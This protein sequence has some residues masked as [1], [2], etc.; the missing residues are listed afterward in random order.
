MS[1]FHT[2]SHVQILKNFQSSKVGLSL[3]VVSERQIYSKDLQIKDDKSGSLLLKFL[4]Q[5]SD[6]MV[7]ILLFASLT[8]IVVGIIQ[9]SSAEIVDGVIIFSIVF[10]NALF[11]FIQE[12]KSEKAISSLK[13]MAEPEC[14]VIRQGEAFKIPSCSLVCG[15]IVVLESGSQ[16]PADCR[17]IE[18]FSLVV[19]ESSL[20]G[21]SLPVKKNYAEI[22]NEK[23]A[24]GDRSN[25]VF[26]GTTVTGGRGVCIVCAIG[27]ETE[28]GKIAL[29]IKETKKELTPLQ[30][31]I[32]SV[33][34]VLTYLI[35]LIAFVTFVLEIVA[36]GNPM[37]AFLTAIAISV[38]AI[39][40][41]LP[42]VI[43]IIMSIGIFRLAKQKAIVKRMH[44]VETLGCCDVICSDKTGTITQNKMTVVET[45]CDGS[46]DKTPNEE[47]FKIISLCNDTMKG[48]KGFAGDPTEIAISNFAKKHGYDK[49]LMEK[50]FER[51]NEKSFDS[52]RRMMSVVNKC[53][54][55]TMFTK[56]A[57]WEVLNSCDRIWTDGKERLLTDFDRKNILNANE[58]MTQKA[59]RVLSLAF[60][61]AE[62]DK[63]EE[64]GLVFVGLVGMIDPPRKQT[65]HAVERCKKAGIRTIMITGDHKSTAFAIAKQVKIAQSEKEVFTGSEI[66][67]MGDEQL[68]KALKKASVFARVS[69]E[70]KSRLVKILKENGHIVGMTGD[71]VNDAPSIKSA[72]IGIGMGQ[73]GVD[74]TKEVADIIIT[75]DNFSTIVVAVE[76]GRKIF[77]NIQKTVKFLF[78]ANMA[79]IL[80]LFLMTIIFPKLTFLLP[81]QILFVNLITDSLPA[82]ALGVEKAENNIMEES[83]RSKKSN[84]FSNGVW[85]EIVVMGIVQTIL[86]M[87]SYVIGL[88]LVSE[89]TAVTM[90]FYTLNLLQLFYLF[91]VRTDKMVFKTNPFKNK[92]FTLSMI[93]GFGMLLIIALTPLSKVL[94][95]V[96]LSWNMWLIVFAIS[97]LVIFFNEIYKVINNKFKK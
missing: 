76:E 34:K 47:F 14:T 63:I 92:L 90:A 32:K 67:E 96:E 8:S 2:Y 53:D 57:I 5:F 72:S 81:I 79:E 80:S 86:I 21:E 10:V 52:E 77:K 18:S 56:G 70:N 58:K 27:I 38:A 82:I 50:K 30:K 97:V 48:E 1:K 3:S 16:V 15:D 74:V 33:G 88:Y 26:K 83:P 43:T 36:R 40:E 44:S 7:L 39:P 89:Q 37:Q 71:G 93:F 4:M 66:D 68:S 94:G 75:D 35:L 31:N 62:G 55:L 25:M 19:D 22:L 84:L 46:F 85:R 45:F 12:Y 95:L 91:S 20:T 65:L 42:A 78:S 17:L 51:V 87:S 60:K 28:I 73:S 59:L 29:V 23:T 24:L 64:K 54:N 69:P 6:L 9:K 13:K 49:I 41:S 61:K 11:G